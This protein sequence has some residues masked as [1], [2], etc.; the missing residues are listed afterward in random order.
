MGNN[1]EYF[2]FLLEAHDR[3]NNGES[4][5][6]ILKEFN[7]KFG[8]NIS[9]KALCHRVER[10]TKSANKESFKRA[11]SINH[12]NNGGNT[13]QPKRN[14]YTTIDGNGILTAQRFLQCQ[15]SVTNDP[16]KLLTELGYNP[17]QW[18]IISLTTKMWEQGSKEGTK[19]LYSIGIKLKRKTELSNE[20]VLNS[21]KAVINENI[22]PVKFET[23]DYNEDYNPNLMMEICPIELHMGK[24]SNAD[25]TGENYDLKICKNIFEDLVSRICKIQ[26][27]KK[28]NKAL[29]II[30]S[31][32]FNSESDNMTT[33]KTPQQNDTR[34]KKLFLTGL[35]LYTS[36]LL[37]FREIFNEVEVRICSGNH[38]RAM[39]F[40]LY[41]A[42][43]QYF[44][45]DDIVTFVDDYKDTQA[46]QF[47]KCA[48]FYNHGDANLK[49]TIASMPAEFYE[50]WG[51]T[52]YRELHLGHLHKEVT[53]DDE[54]G[55][56]TRRIG[57]PCATD[58][59]HYTNRFIG[60]VKKH[61]IFIWDKDN[62]L[63]EIRYLNSNIK[64]Y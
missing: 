47:G 53:V 63:Q 43:A 2:N 30:G 9:R 14:E 32:F 56:I 7:E 57:S 15:K 8:E 34:Y 17:S 52:I 41:T 33:N 1:E 19:D 18:D 26:Q 23:L 11:V 31:D 51:K 4:W 58:A 44:K 24:L 42:L 35:K 21:L 10:Y 49:R 46:I 12:N 60:A 22:K 16:D 40:F 25:E 64:S 3:R 27:E 13:F 37:T 20:D 6:E 39:E 45:N 48:I 29:V 54:S 55:M 50:I 36:A 38:A 61:Q 59:W 5:G 28:C 62:G